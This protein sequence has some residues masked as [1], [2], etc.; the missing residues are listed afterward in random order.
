[1]GLGGFIR[2]RLRAAR[3]LYAIAFGGVLSIVSFNVGWHLDVPDYNG[4][5][6]VAYWLAAAG[7]A[8]LFAT[9]LRAR[10]F[11]A[12]AAIVVCL[13]AGV[14]CSPALW[15]RTRH[16]DRV[17][18]T[19]TEQVLQE[20]P[21]DAIVISSA[22]Y[23][24]G[25]LFYLQEAESRRPDVAVLAYGLA[26]SSW[27][28]RHLFAVHPELTPVDLQKRGP[29]AQR[30]RAFLAAN[31]ERPVLIERYDVG[32]ELGLEL[33]PG[34]VYLR[35]GTLCRAPRPSGSAS[36]LLAE[37]LQRV[38]DGSPSAAAGLA[39]IGEQLGAA[40][41]R[42]RQP[43]EAHAVLLAT[44]PRNAW[45]HTLAD[46]AQL[47]HAAMSGMAVPPW[48]RAEALGEPSR[49]I[50]LAGAIVFASGQTEVAGEYVRAAARLGLPEARE[51]LA[52]TKGP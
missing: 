22:D 32:R 21:A 2:A 17:A 35:A 23:F 5:L 29:R 44:V 50:F 8:A 36:D 9:S 20:A 42:L 30:V 6:A 25:S 46:P 4:Y 24:A 43:E 11:G 47:Q 31:P 3:W 33:C 28:W 10:R 18:R 52:A 27:H 45:P 14:V 37:Q 1:V 51:L 34:G 7:S 48:R 13:G 19:L 40:L 26:G 41:W 16:V 15:M 49:N 12:C 39:E 38:S